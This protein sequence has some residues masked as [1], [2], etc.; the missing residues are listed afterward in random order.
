MNLNMDEQNLMDETKFRAIYGEINTDFHWD[1]SNTRLDAKIGDRVYGSY[2]TKSR[3]Q[4]LEEAQTLTG[5]F[6]TACIVAGI[7]ATA[8]VA[9]NILVLRGSISPGWAG[10]VWPLAGISF[11][12][13]AIGIGLLARRHVLLKSYYWDPQ[14]GSE[15]LK[16]L[17]KAALSGI[18]TL[19]VL[20]ILVA[21]C[22]EQNKER[23]TY[24]NHRGD[25]ARCANDAFWCLMGMQFQSALYDSARPRYVIERPAPS[26]T[27][28]NVTQVTQPI[29][30]MQSA[31]RSE[32]QQ[33]LERF[34]NPHAFYHED[35]I[36][37]GAPTGHRQSSVEMSPMSA[38]SVGGKSKGL[39]ST[40][41]QQLATEGSD[42][43]EEGDGTVNRKR[44]RRARRVEESN[45]GVQTTSRAR[46]ALAPLTNSD[47]LTTTRGG[48][49]SHG[50]QPPPPPYADSN[51]NGYFADTEDV[52]MDDA[53]G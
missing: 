44:R 41:E 19:G 5:Q 3:G 2:F 43:D 31:G 34:N 1:E 24:A 40:R 21:C 33:Y 52:D 35:E 50:P 4:V 27:I 28:V 39:T 12:A 46:R 14:T 9:I 16:G 11:G 51:T 17:G 10:A 38:S 47:S 26:V 18:I 48:I 36:E 7:C 53:D 32:Y 25:S 29:I 49:Q 23:Q 45:D 22:A 20:L 6:H 13:T 30:V 15:A 8:A 42:S 37:P